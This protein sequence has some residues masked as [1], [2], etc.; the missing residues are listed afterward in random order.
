MWNLVTGQEIVTLRGHP[1]NVVSV[2]YCS[3]SSLVFSVSTSYVKVWD[4]RDSAKCVRTFTS[5]GQVVS[6]DACAGTTTRTISMA[7]GEYQINQIALNPS[8]S[9][10]YAAAGNTVRTWDL[11]RMQATGKLTGHIGSV[12]CLTVGY[13]AGGK[14]QGNKAVTVSPVDRKTE[15]TFTHGAPFA[16]EP[17]GMPGIFCLACSARGLTVGTFPQVFDVAEGAQGNVGPAHNFEPPHY[18]GIEC[19]AIHDDVLFSGSRDNGIKKWDLEQQEL[20]QQIPNAHKDWVCALACLPGRPTLLSA[21]RGGSLKVWNVDNFTPIGEIKGHDS[22]INAIC[23]NSKQIFTASRYI[24]VSGP[25][26]LRG[27]AGGRA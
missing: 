2:K 15:A 14:D 16:R 26:R 9:V 21:C 20:I 19:L 24:Q 1:N 7:Q 22:P 6:G 25:G 5:S 3:S 12:M 11:N 8:G 23:T 10:L 13:S 17:H 4:I 27:D 18:D